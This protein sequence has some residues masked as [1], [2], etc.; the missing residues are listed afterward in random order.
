MQL[1]HR[2]R[3]LNM[4][5]DCMPDRLTIQIAP[6]HPPVI[7]FK[8]S[9]LTAMRV[10][11]L[12]LSLSFSLSLSLSLPLSLSLSLS[13]HRHTHTHM[14]I[15]WGAGQRAAPTVRPR[16]CRTA[17]AIARAQHLAG[18]WWAA[19]SNTAP[20]KRQIAQRFHASSAS[21]QH[22]SRACHANACAYGNAVDANR[23]QDHPGVQGPGLGAWT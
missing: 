16:F 20:K 6:A 21:R 15:T 2:T 9:K 13:L 1:V 22:R 14:Y 10:L 18:A 5:S 8:A 19:Q 11:F 17:D 12:S 4:F 7:A 3:N 23:K